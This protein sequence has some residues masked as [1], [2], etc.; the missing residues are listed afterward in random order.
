MNLGGWA[1]RYF[2]QILRS[3][4]SGLNGKHILKQNR[5]CM[6]K[7]HSS[8]KGRGFENTNSSNGWDE[9]AVP[10]AAAQ[11]QRMTMHKRFIS[12]HRKDPHISR[13]QLTVDV[14]LQ[15]ARLLS[16][17]QLDGN[18]KNGKA[19]A[20]APSDLTNVTI[21]LKM[22]WKFLWMTNQNILCH[23]IL[24]I[25]TPSDCKEEFWFGRNLYLWI[26]ASVA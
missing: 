18:Q 25:S 4:T 23:L 15:D 21:G 20:A 9:L 11:N 22:F 1:P 8:F 2:S 16:H 26:F 5:M 24:S 14:Q 19:K 6:C 7:D 17:W 3:R 13:C 12:A 10:D